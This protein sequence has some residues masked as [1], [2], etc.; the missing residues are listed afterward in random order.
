MSIRNKW[1][2]S[3]MQHLFVSCSG[4]VLL[5]ALYLITGWSPSDSNISILERFHIGSEQW[6]RYQIAYIVGDYFMYFITL[7]GLSTL[8][9]KNASSINQWGIVAGLAG[10]TTPMAHRFWPETE[11]TPYE[12]MVMLILGATL[13]AFCRKTHLT[14]RFIVMTGMA[15]TTFIISIHY[16]SINFALLPIMEFLQ[17][18][19]EAPGIVY[20][21]FFTLI[22]GMYFVFNLV[23]LSGLSCVTA[24]HHRVK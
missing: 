17:G 3:A 12:L 11:L 6:S 14:Q 15:Y 24:I 7:M 1:Q 21:A 10:I 2:F 19:M 23:W 13:I 8:F 20:P 16:W 5:F 9:F 18:N 22:Y 4:I